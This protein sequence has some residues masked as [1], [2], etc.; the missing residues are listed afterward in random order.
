[1]FGVTKATVS[2]TIHRVSAVLADRVDEHVKFEEI[3]VETKK[4][5]FA[6]RGFPGVIGAI[7]CTHIKIL[8]PTKHENIYVCRKGSL[9][10]TCSVAWLCVKNTM[11]KDNVVH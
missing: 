1:V 3:C 4:K 5:F 11:F 9:F 7:D 2:S 10:V 8:A 6:M